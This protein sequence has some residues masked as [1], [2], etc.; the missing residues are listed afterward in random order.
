MTK[1][2]K[3]PTVV[4]KKHFGNINMHEDHTTAIVSLQLKFVQSIIEERLWNR[5]KDV[6]L[7]EA[8]PSLLSSGRNFKYWFRLCP[9]TFPQE[10][11]RT[12]II[13]EDFR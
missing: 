13:W 12:G 6:S 5:F 7:E 1:R 11:H 3:K 8:Y 2:Q 4:M 9:A 10:K